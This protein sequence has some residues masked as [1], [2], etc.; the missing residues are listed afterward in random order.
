[1]PDEAELRASA[2]AE[3]EAKPQLTV[4][5]LEKHVR[6]QDVLG[7]VAG[8]RECIGIGAPRLP[9]RRPLVATANAESAQGTAS[10]GMS[11]QLVDG[12]V[13]EYRTVGIDAAGRKG[14]VAADEK[15]GIAVAHDAHQE[16]LKVVDIA[17]TRIPLPRHGH[18]LGPGRCFRGVLGQTVYLATLSCH[19]AS[20]PLRAALCRL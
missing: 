2:E 8:D 15:P 9:E 6:P 18:E 17:Y 3:G 10:V 20:A 12:L 13:R 1:M 7:E 14:R 11:Q 19:G 16:W 4:D 5:L